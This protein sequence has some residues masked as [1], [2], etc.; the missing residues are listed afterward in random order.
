[1]SALHN[2]HVLASSSSTGRNI[3]G[4]PRSGGRDDGAFMINPDF[5]AEPD[6]PE[7]GN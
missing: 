3:P 5:Q 7:S 2:E 1:M 4:R 6:P